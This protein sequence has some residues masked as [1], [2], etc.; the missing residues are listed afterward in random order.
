MAIAML[1]GGLCMAT[2]ATR[3]TSTSAAEQPAD[4]AKPACVGVTSVMLNPRVIR[5]YRAFDDGTV[6]AFDDGVADS[7][8]KKVGK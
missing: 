7:T 1:A 2:S 4:R 8:W 3:S 5:V 6:E